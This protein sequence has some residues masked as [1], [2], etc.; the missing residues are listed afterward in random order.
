M[1]PF[2]SLYH[3]KLIEGYC[4]KEGSLEYFSRI[5]GSDYENATNELD[6][7]KISRIGF[8]SYRVSRGNSIFASAIEKSLLNGINLID[9]SSNYGDGGSESL[10]GDVIFNL[11]EK[12]KLKREEIFIV[13]K[14]GYIQ[15]KNLEL[16]ESFEKEEK[17]FSEI[18]YYDSNCYHC[19][20]PD[21]LKDQIERARKRL[22]LFTLDALLLHNPEYFLMDR[23]KHNV[24]QEKASEDY[25]DR[26]KRAF[27]FLEEMRINGIIRYY[28]ISSNTFPSEENS[29]THTSL[30]KVHNIALEIQKK[31]NL[32][33][34]GF[35]VIQFP[36]NLYET[37]FVHE[38][39]S[40]GASISEYAFQ[41]SFYTLINRPLNA[42]KK[43]GGMD[44]LAIYSDNLDSV[45]LEL[46]EFTKEFSF[47]QGEMF[48]N[49]GIEKED[50]TFLTVLEDYKDK[51]VSVEHFHQTLNYSIIPQIKKLLKR[52]E[53]LDKKREFYENYID[54][55][56]S[57]ISKLES[58]LEAKQSARM[59][60]LLAKLESKNTLFK[61]KSLSQAAVLS[62]LGF[63]G[64][65]SILA[66][67]RKEKYVNDI[68]P[69]LKYEIP[70]LTKSDLL[71]IEI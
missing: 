26:I 38:L 29:Y 5:F 59:K 47:H 28:G 16:V 36:A 68:L 12:S 11:F 30:S 39:N 19:I 3:N 52:I 66:G 25:Y 40:E 44:R 10:I 23:Q 65:N 37:G 51:F 33:S 32:E 49:L 63:K 45:N 6:E 41:N 22:G 34:T 71:D 53:T 50:Y 61:N 58:Y 70:I 35:R 27:E 9:T 55:L 17:S 62:L 8:G 54:L 7:I 24:S 60:P 43:K 42:M 13:T 56:N 64:I 14:I 69:I 21:F 46:K 15:G 48:I 18:T 4:T 57:G 1:D 31:L 67:M 2:E 20:S